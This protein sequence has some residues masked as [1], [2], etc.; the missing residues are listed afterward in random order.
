V[1]KLRSERVQIGGSSIVVGRGAVG[2]KRGSRISSFFLLEH[3]RVIGSIVGGQN[4][5]LR[6]DHQ[7][8]LLL[9]R[10]PQSIT[11]PLFSDLLL[12]LMMTAVALSPDSP[13]TPN[14]TTTN[15]CRR[16]TQQHSHHH[17]TPSASPPP[18]RRRSVDQPTLRQADRVLHGSHER[19]SI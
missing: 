17:V 1:V 16:A 15:H 6:C 14:L 8:P 11:D 4:V 3:Q 18:P 7:L 10:C 12:L 2:M 5:A 19:F 9:R 13:N